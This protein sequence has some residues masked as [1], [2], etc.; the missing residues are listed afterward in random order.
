M[1]EAW[2]ELLAEVHRLLK[3]L[4]WRKEGGNFRL[5]LPDGL[6][7]IIQAG[8]DNNNMTQIISGIIMIGLGGFILTYIM[9][10]IE[11]VACRWNRSGR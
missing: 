8:M 6:G 7:W 11:G 9:R 1:E 2:R 10:T 3:P 5:F 4:G